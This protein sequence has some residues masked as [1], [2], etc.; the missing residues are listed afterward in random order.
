M[1]TDEE[2]LIFSSDTVN[3]EPLWKELYSKNRPQRLNMSRKGFESATV[4]YGDINSYI[5]R[6][7][8]EER[9]KEAVTA[10][11]DATII[12]D[13]S[14]RNSGVHTDYERL[15]D[16]TLKKDSTIL[17]H[18]PDKITSEWALSERARPL[19]SKATLSLR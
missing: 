16:S 11:N 15:E 8:S 13:L 12:H 18:S 9:Y 10:F 19:G 14:V 2:T 7:W 4:I 3:N 6:I 17:T 1:K 5:E